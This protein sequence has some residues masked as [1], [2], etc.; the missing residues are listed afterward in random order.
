M[1]VTEEGRPLAQPEIQQSIDKQTQL[2]KVLGGFSLEGNILQHH[3]NRYTPRVSKNR[4][5]DAREKQVNRKIEFLWLLY[6]SIVRATGDEAAA[7]HYMKDLVLNHGEFDQVE[8]DE[9]YDF[10]SEEMYRD[11]FAS[12]VQQEK[13]ELAVRRARTILGGGEVASALLAELNHNTS[14]DEVT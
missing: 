10:S 8:E 11:F 2:R 14:R 12:L 9:E 1:T 7:D 5:S 13:Y 6:E 3:E 4:C